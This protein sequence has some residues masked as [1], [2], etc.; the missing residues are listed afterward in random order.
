MGDRAFSEIAA[1]RK[2]MA[3]AI[4]SRRRRRKPSRPHDGADFQTFRPFAGKSISIFWRA[5]LIFRRKFK[6]TS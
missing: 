4:T 2:E 3:R 1:L 6:L 5:I